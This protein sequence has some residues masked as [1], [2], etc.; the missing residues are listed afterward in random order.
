MKKLTRDALI[1][2]RNYVKTRGRELD[3]DLFAYHFEG[4]GKVGV[5]RA[6]MAYQNPDGGFGHGLEPDL[7][8]PASSA[9]ATQ[10]A[11]NYL[12]E[13]DAGIDQ[14]LVRRGIG[15]LLNTFDTE[16][17]VWPI[18]PPEV[19]DE[20]HAPWWSYEDSADN[21]GGFLANPRAAL[22]G[23]LN[24][25]PSLVPADFLVQVTGDVLDHLGKM[26]DDKMDMHDLSCYLTLAESVP[27]P[28]RDRVV[29]KLSRVTADS[30]E[31]DP[32][33]WSEYNLKPLA[34]AP[35]PDGLLHPVLDRQALDANL[36]GEIE[37]QLP[38]GSWPL[39][40]SWEFVDEAA[41]TQ[42]EQDW[43]GHHVVQKLKTLRAYGRL[44][45]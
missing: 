30:V 6:L 9:I 1:R 43:K 33:K 26:P 14:E 34:V 25:Y 17:G 5:I 28:I 2:A 21:F 45:E 40:W 8:T 10:Q 12:R 16:R 27:S 7:R 42:A 39:S 20:P 18:V 41:W 32:D 15:Y 13:I 35:T 22:V 44:Q 31:N 3:R 38:D 24:H 4:G 37:Q 36:D 29:A 11:F 19:E 23:H